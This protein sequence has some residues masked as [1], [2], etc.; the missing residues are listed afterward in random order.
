MTPDS[1][2]TIEPAS[3]ADVPVILE[4]IRKLAEYER[5]SHEIKATEADLRRHLFG[6][7]PAAEA[8]IA[9]LGGRPVGYALFFTTFS[10]FVGRP[11]IWLEDVFVLPDDR[12]RGIGR[13]LLRHVAAIAVQR[14]CGRLEWSVLDWNEPAIKFYREIGAEPMS[15]WTVQRLAG[16]M[17]KRFA[18]P[19]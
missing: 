10:T 11:G 16:H 17:L 15:E 8:I 9:R 7:R 4:F 1:N 3:P 19:T 12:R 6:A 2:L 5:L 13:A 18:E 14:N